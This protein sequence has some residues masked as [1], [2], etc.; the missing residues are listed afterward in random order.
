MNQLTIN[1]PLFAGRT[2]EPEYDQSRLTGQWLRVW[3][4]MKSGRWRT[5]GG[6]QADIH[7]TGHHDSEAGIGARLRDFRKTKFGGHTVNRRR[8]GDPKSGL[9]EY[10]LVIK[11]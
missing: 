8:R 7:A 9:F 6:I 3:D 5:L 10:R 4:V 1:G 2:Y 11:R